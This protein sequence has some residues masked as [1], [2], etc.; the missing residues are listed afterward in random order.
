[1]GF[2]FLAK[3]TAPSCYRTTPT[4]ARTLCFLCF[5]C[6]V[7]FSVMESAAGPRWAP[8]DVALKRID[9]PRIKWQ[10]FRLL[11]SSPC[12]YWST[13]KKIVQPHTECPVD[14]AQNVNRV[15]W[16]SSS[17]ADEPCESSIIDPLRLNPETFQQFPWFIQTTLWETLSK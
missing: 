6:S 4:C 9:P 3:K 14:S 17:P 13:P 1:M 11:H 16:W 5:T 7:H 12:P 8:L 10:H 15:Q 2:V